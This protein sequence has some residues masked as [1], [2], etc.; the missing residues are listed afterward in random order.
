MLEHFDFH[1]LKD[2]GKAINCHLLTLVISQLSLV[3]KLY[4]VHWP[5]KYWLAGLEENGLE[6]PEHPS[7]PLLIYSRI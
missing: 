7:L 1:D 6:V 5:R 2:K 4:L 3:H